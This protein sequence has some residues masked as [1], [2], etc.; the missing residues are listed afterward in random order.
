MKEHT[1]AM[2]LELCLLKKHCWGWFLLLYIFS[3]KTMLW[4]LFSIC[5]F[6]C[7][8]HALRTTDYFTAVGQLWV[9]LQ[10]DTFHGNL[11]QIVIIL[12]RSRNR[13]YLT[14]LASADTCMRVN[15]TRV[16]CSCQASSLTEHPAQWMFF[17]TN[18]LKI[19]AL[20]CL[21][22]FISFSYCFLWRMY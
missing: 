7:F 13:R 4:D 3:P 22:T 11:M 15:C 18:K 6:V 8:L 14:F 5:V 12:I 1:K 17:T 20:V 16:N 21:E 2:I 19:N 9:V 10:G